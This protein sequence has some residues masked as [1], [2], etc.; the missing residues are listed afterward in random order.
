[1]NRYRIVLLILAMSLLQACSPSH[2]KKSER[3]I[4]VESQ[5]LIDTLFYSG[6]IQPLAATIIS[7]PVDGVITGTFFQYGDD[8]NANQLIFTISSTKFLSDYKAALMQYVKAKSEFNNSQ[9]QL[10]EADFLHH[11][12]LISDDDYKMRQANFYASRLAFVQ[13]K[14][15]LSTLMQQL[16]IKDID[17]NKLS[18]ADIDK[19]TEAM[20]FKFDSEQLRI[21]TPAQGVILSAS[22]NEEET[23]KLAQGDSIKQGD[24]LALIGDMQGLSVRIRVNEITVNQLKR[25]QKVKVTGIAFPN[26]ILQGEIKQVDRQGETANGGLP[27]FPVDIIVPHLTKAQRALIHVGMSAKV[28]IDISKPARTMIPVFAIVERSGQYYV[29]ILDAKTK[30]THEA[31][32]RTGETTPNAVEVLAGLQ[33]GDTI[34]IPH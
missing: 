9:S 3:T 8:V 16:E 2:E 33:P 10:A 7:S 11:N 22:K 31:L 21:V 20:R 24:V 19:I 27:T 1:M 29:N 30:K 5:V 18:I 28:E 15:A 14:D 4:H 13:A 32:V 12:E 26:D 25:G 6:T 17:L 23:K 34:V